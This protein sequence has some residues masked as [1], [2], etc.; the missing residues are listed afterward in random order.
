M[1][2]GFV[3]ASQLYWQNE[4]RSPIILPWVVLRRLFNFGRYSHYQTPPSV[5][6]LIDISHTALHVFQSDVVAD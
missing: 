5:I 2:N 4:I 3:K 1:L 6:I